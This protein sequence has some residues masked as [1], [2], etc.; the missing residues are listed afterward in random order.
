MFAPESLSLPGKFALGADAA[1]LAYRL[2]Q[3]GRPIRFGK[4]T[5]DMNVPLIAI[6]ATALSLSDGWYVPSTVIGLRQPVVINGV[7]YPSGYTGVVPSYRYN[8]A[9]PI[10]S[11]AIYGVPTYGGGG[12]LLGPSVY[13]SPVYTGSS[14]SLAAYGNAYPSVYKS[15]TNYAYPSGYNGQSSYPA[16][17]SLSTSQSINTPVNAGNR[18]RADS[19]I[20]LT[21]R[22]A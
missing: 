10:Y 3:T 14:F 13:T 1:L 8:G 17:R 4:H 18:D 22:S 2:R 20:V 12:G 16:A 9:F 7:T 5:K 19:T 15:Y 21:N 6:L 11:T